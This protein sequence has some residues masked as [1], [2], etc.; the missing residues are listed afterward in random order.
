MKLLQAGKHV[1]K[2]SIDKRIFYRIYHVLDEVI[3]EV[4]V[5]ELSVD[6]DNP[7]EL[8]LT[9]IQPGDVSEELQKKIFFDE[10][11]VLMTQDDKDLITNAMQTKYH[12]YQ[13]ITK[14]FFEKNA[15]VLHFIETGGHYF[16]FVSEKGAPFAKLFHLYID[17]ARQKVGVGGV[18]TIFLASL[19]EGIADALLSK[20]KTITIQI[21]EGVY[22][23][24]S[25]WEKSMKK[26]VAMVAVADENEKGEAGFRL[27]GGF[28]LKKLDDGL[29]YVTSLNELEKKRFDKEIEKKFDEFYEELSFK[30]YLATGYL[31]VESEDEKEKGAEA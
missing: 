9:E 8:S 27:A 31:P 10:H 19:L 7:K 5:F 22:T 21:G 25:L 29:W 26:A 1:S 20:L 2:L 11:K 17:P 3:T 6:P 18:D 30:F 28:Y 24:L 12:F 4:T 14:K 23:K 15:K 13:E 16:A